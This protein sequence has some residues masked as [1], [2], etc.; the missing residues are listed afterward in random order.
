MANKKRKKSLF[1]VSK[2]ILFAGLLIMV[3]I[4][5]YFANV[6]VNRNQTLSV[7]ATAGVAELFFEPSSLVLSPDGLVNLWVTTDKQLGFFATDLTFDPSII[8]LAQEITLPTTGLAKKIRV[9]SMSEA[10]ATGKISIVLGV[11]PSAISTAPTGTFKIANLKF[12]KKS[13]LANKST[14]LSIVPSA[15]QLVD[16]GAIPFN[17]STK[18][19]SFTLNPVASATP[20]PPS[21]STTT[22]GA[23]PIITN[24]S[25]AENS[26]IPRGGVWV[27]SVVS[28]PDGVSQTTF[29]FDDVLIKTCPA[30]QLECNFTY[31]KRTSSGNHVIRVEAID[32]SPSKNK[33]QTIIN[34][35][36]QSR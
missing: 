31:R 5:L 10:N 3:S 34:V 20:A 22:N 18:N 12:S 11:E 32:N 28:D 7:G 1:S 13:T 24:K 35:V 19:A 36:K 9:T 33:S 30:N 15:T 8:S 17:S 16:M 29:Y 21:T 27:G 4:T 25:P 14:L 6:L 26:K 2:F 23:G